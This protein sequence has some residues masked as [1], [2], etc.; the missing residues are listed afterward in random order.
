MLRRLFLTVFL[1]CAMTWSFSS[2]A[3][4]VYKVSVSLLHQGRVFGAPVVVV[5]PGVP[6]S[7]KVS[8]AQGQGYT[9]TL[10]VTALGHDKFRI[11]THLDS[12]WGSIAPELEVVAGKPASVSVGDI[13][14]DIAVA[15]Q[16][17]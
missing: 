1:L 12:A 4:T 2:V 11:R 16:R 9:L 17:S 15:Q 5:K 7:V 3:A 14:C 8:G 6:A 13:E 10:T